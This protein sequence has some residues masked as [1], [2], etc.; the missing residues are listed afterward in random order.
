[1]EDNLKHDI[2]CPYVKTVDGGSSCCLGVHC[3]IFDKEHDQC[4]MLTLV[5]SVGELIKLEQAATKE[6]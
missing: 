5:N 1:M 4:V 3:G 2:A 6:G